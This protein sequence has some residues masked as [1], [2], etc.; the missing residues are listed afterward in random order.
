MAAH[1]TVHAFHVIVPFYRF[2]HGTD[3]ELQFTQLVP[4]DTCFLQEV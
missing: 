2:S 3:T 1:D 4:L